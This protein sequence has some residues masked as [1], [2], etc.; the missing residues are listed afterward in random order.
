M[1]IVIAGKQFEVSDEQITKAIEDKTELKLD[2]DVVIREKDEETKFI[3][4]TREEARKIGVEIAVKE[5][6]TK[7]GLNFEG[8]KTLDN[9]LDAVTAKTL[10]DAKIEPEQKVK[11]LQKDIETLK[12]TI[13]SITGERDSI[14]TDFHRFKSDS[15]VN[16]TIA[17]MIPENTTL[18][19]DDMILL[20]KNK[21]QFEVNESN[22]I[23]VKGSNGE[24]MKNTTTL[25]PLQ[26][27]EVIQSFFDSHPVYLKGASGGAGGGDSADNS[28]K[29]TTDQFIEKKA[30]E[31][32]SHTDPKFM[33]EYESLQ[34]QGL[35]AD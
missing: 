11:E 12:G 1:K 20:L 10:E 17:S 25:D 26:P 19:K 22:A 4:N 16:T 34:K 9:L 15:L 18:P 14:K 3:E 2:S 31:G 7:L 24:V 35:I 29:M 8:K 6:R 27:K 21:M 33:N 13:G 23:I 30:K 32:I 5:A 28:G